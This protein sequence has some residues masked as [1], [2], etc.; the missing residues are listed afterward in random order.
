M[1][2][3]YTYTGIIGTNYTFLNIA[4]C[5]IAAILGEYLQFTAPFEKNM[6]KMFD[7]F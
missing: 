2:L 6:T 7:K 4:T 1:K 3:F 5:V